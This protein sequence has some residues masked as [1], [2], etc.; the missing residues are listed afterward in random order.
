MTS[1]LE[2]A[3]AAKMEPIEAVAWKARHL[4]PRNDAYGQRCCE[5]MATK[6]RFLKAPR[7]PRA[8]LPLSTQRPSE[9]ERRSPPS[10]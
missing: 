3:R 5:N 1:D 4:R 10:D 7:Q 9:K 8:G 6:E 2:I